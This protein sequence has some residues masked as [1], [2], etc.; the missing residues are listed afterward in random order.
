MIWSAIHPRNYINLFGESLPAVVGMVILVKT[1]NKF[2]FT[3]FTYCVVLASCYCI[4]IG[5]HY[6]YARVPLFNF[7]RDTFDLSRNHFDRFGHFIQG[8]IPVLVTRELFIR[9]QLITRY[10]LISLLAFC[11]CLASTAFYELVEA[12]ACWISGLEL[13]IFLGTQGDQ[14]DSQWDMLFAALGGLTMI[15]LFRK[16]HDRIIEKEFPG[17]FELFY[18]RFSKPD[19]AVGTIE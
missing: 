17:T 11:V 6:S 1:F 3:F 2:R 19:T 9:Q 18:N 12:I 5:A 15:F 4:F 16:L 7:I 13:D 14:W 8:I 10:Q